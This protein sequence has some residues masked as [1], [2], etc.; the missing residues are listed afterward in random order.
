[1]GEQSSALYT[2]MPEKDDPEPLSRLQEDTEQPLFLHFP[3]GFC[4]TAAVQCSL[5]Y[6]Y[7]LLFRLL[8]I[9]LKG[10]FI[11]QAS[12]PTKN[13]A[14]HIL[15]TMALMLLLVVLPALALAYG[16]GGGGGGNSG[17]SSGFR[18]SGGRGPNIEPMM[19][20]EGLPVMPAE[21][22]NHTGTT[23]GEK[24]GVTPGP[25]STPKVYDWIGDFAMDKV[26]GSAIDMVSAVHPGLGLAIGVADKVYGAY[27]YGKQAVQKL[28]ATKKSYQKSALGNLGSGLK[29][30]NPDMMD[31]GPSLPG[32]GGPQ[33]RQ[34]SIQLW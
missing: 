21:G 33:N 25:T 27:D 11:M 1:M 32:G 23:P 31:M 4:Y 22:Y 20:V 12:S 13:N 24:S 15:A 19:G 3:P 17:S 30:P 6:H 16:G 29:A 10:V 2:C 9:F 5:Y 26:K 28:E 14:G 8:D 34:E 18:S 7:S